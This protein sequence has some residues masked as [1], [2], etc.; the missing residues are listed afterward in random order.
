MKTVWEDRQYQTPN[1][2]VVVHSHLEQ[3]MHSRGSSNHDHEQGFPK[4]E[5]E[6]HRFASDSGLTPPHVRFGVHWVGEP[7]P[8]TFS[9]P[10]R[11]EGHMISHTL[12]DRMHV[13]SF[14]NDTGKPFK[15][16][17]LDSAE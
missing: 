14:F 5:R 15:R 9:K 17:E 8:K 16:V 12:V 1:T 3:L 4:I 10:P 7:N 13:I 11:L 2:V 6:I